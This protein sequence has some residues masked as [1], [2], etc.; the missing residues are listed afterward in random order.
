MSNSVPKEL[1]TI[2]QTILGKR[3]R[4]TAPSPVSVAESLGAVSSSSLTKS[5]TS[6]DLKELS[7]SLTKISLGLNNSDKKSKEESVAFHGPYDSDDSGGPLE[8]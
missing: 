5:P 8:F 6:F 7:N 3:K 4:E 1:S 2:V